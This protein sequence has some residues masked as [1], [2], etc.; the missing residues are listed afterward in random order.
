M[1]V[2]LKV[3]DGP[4]AGGVIAVDEG[5]PVTVG[6]SRDPGVVAVPDQAMSRLHFVVERSGRSCRIRD[7]G[8]SNGTFVNAAQVT[9]AWLQAGDR[10]LA[11][12]TTFE[13][14]VEAEAAP[15]PPAPAP[16]PP[17]PSR[18][19]PP[20][21]ARPPPT[22]PDPAFA[23]ALEDDDETVRREALWAAAWTGQPW[24]RGYLRALLANPEPA[25]RDA[26]L[27]LAI[28][29]GPED[30]ELV[31]AAARALDPGPERFRVLAAFG[32]PAVVDELLAGIEDEDAAVAAAAGEAFEKLTGAELDRIPAGP[33]EAPAGADPGDATLRPDP[34]AAKLFWRDAHD[35]FFQS[36][37]WCRGLDLSGEIDAA[38]INRLDLQSRLEACVRGRYL[39]SW[40]GSPADLERLGGLRP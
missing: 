14:A 12:D 32:H 1:R 38:T 33:E 13:V 16:P 30:V 24:L 31:L 17:A 37:R 34:A 11:G 2:L 23:A 35:R 28:L 4:L 29:G 3:L 9:D 7:L 40:S 5:V 8:S 26:M 25:H 27:L 39:G 22:R 36:S 6:R 18:A 10:I 19:P 21:H 15:P 20:T